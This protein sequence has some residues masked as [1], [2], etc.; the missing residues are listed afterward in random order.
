MFT[1][2]TN[3]FWSLV[4]TGLADVKNLYSSLRM[5]GLPITDTEH[6]VTAI[7]GKVGHIKR[8]IKLPFS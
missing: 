4:V 1:D 6:K 5:A 3:K 7:S 2:A 8:R